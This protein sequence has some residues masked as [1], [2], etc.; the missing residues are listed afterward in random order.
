MLTTMLALIRLIQVPLGFLGQLRIPNIE[1]FPHIFGFF[2]F[3]SGRISNEISFLDHC[4]LAPCLGVPIFWCML[5]SFW[6]SVLK[7]ME[8]VGEIFWHSQVNDSQLIIA[9][10]QFDATVQ[11][12]CPINIYKVIFLDESYEIICILFSNIFY[13]KIIHNK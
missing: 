11:A 6:I 10:V 1:N 2:L 3:Y 7:F 13:Y 4:V 9:L 5:D 12:S 8:D